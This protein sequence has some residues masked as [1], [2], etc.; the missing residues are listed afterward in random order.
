MAKKKTTKKKG[1]KGKSTKS[2]MSMGSF[3][4]VNKLMGMAAGAYGNTLI[5][6]IPGTG[7]LNPKI[8]AAA[9][10]LGGQWL[11]NQSF[12][13]GALANDS[14]RNGIGDALIYEGVKDLMAGF[15]ISG[16]HRS[17]P[18]GNEFLAVSI[19]GLDDA[20]NVNADVLAADEYDIGESVLSDDLNAVN[21]DLSTVNDDMND[22]ISDD[23]D[24][25][26]D[27]MNDDMNDDLL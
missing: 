5:K 18:R 19:E 20:A 4:D 7:S 23:L 2:K 25:V 16:L 6:K 26:N 15:G 24:S 22:D 9:K 21:D 27:D 11:P 3:V 12:A 13:K 1:K 17:K 10:I 14:M 8:L